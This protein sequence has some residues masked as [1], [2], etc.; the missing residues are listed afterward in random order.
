MA[1]VNRDF[2]RKKNYSS[3][4]IRR[5]RPALKLSKAENVIYV[6]SKSHLKAFFSICEKLIDKKN[7]EEILLYCMGTSISKG[8]CLALELC[9]KYPS[10]QYQTRTF[11]SAV[12]DDLEPTTD[13][14]DHELQK[15]NKSAIEIRIFKPKEVA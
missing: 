1:G 10:Y 8:I 2:P 12:T 15:R 13:D 3:S 14:A 4:H 11:T 9:E 7:F 6:N 5:K